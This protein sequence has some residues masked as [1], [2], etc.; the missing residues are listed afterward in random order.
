MRFS[1]MAFALS[2]CAL[3]A[4]PAAADEIPVSSRVSEVT[5]Y[6]GLAE[7]TR[8][9][10]LTLKQGRH[11]LILQNVPHS[12]RLS[13]LQVEIA[14]ARR[15][16]TQL[17]QD[18]APP[19]DAND[20][21]IEA[22]EARVRAAE[23]RIAAVRDEAERARAGVRAAEASIGFLQQLGG[24]EGLAQA[25]A[26]AL[27]AI[28]RMISEEAAGASQ[29]AVAAEAEARR[30]GLQLEDLEEDLAEARAAL[31]AIS[32]EDRDRLFIAVDIEA[33]Q[34]GDGAVT[35]RY[36]TE[37]AG[38]IGWQPSYEM[39]LS[40]MGEAA[41]EAELTLKRA[42]LLV[43]DTGEN[44]QDVAL[45]LSTAAPSG[46]G[47][48]SAL[49]PWLRRVEAPELPRPQKRLQSFDSELGALAAPAAEAAAV[50]E[51]ALEWSADRSG[52]AVTY[53]FGAPVTVASG[54]DLLRLE[55]DSLTAAAELRAVAVPLRDETAYRVVKF[56]NSFGEQLLGAA[57]VPRFADGKLIA[58][59]RFAGLAPGAEMEA[60]FGPVE[61]LQLRRDV[62]DQSEG[63]QGLISRS[64]QQVQAVEIEVENLTGQDW[65]VRVLDRVPYSQQ[66]DLEIGWSAKPRPAE[67]DVEKQRGILAWD[68][69]LAA[70]E[71]RT[72]RL[73][74]TLNWP[75]GM[76]LR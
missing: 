43:Q 12:A 38:N 73:D 31:A 58:V 48:P 46:Q 33:E 71:S 52:A 34:A 55:M 64:S 72:I 15:I 54:A 4:A 5:L 1:L 22:A 74:T 37:G 18:Y 8:S 24:N 13:T 56:T 41:G 44:W 14:G 10:A 3:A 57:E 70:G 20:P 27:S 25:D 21:E 35:V 7:V 17:R 19:R 40:T 66:D 61:G 49:H 76:V 6:P 50:A 75:E 28:A 30:I 2:C 60:G 11:R 9:A 26:A 29:A 45:T 16:A 36:L 59:E 51:E 69:E 63:G 23:A 32:L 47:S 53:R 42:V 39:H 67:E 62:L 68:L 65:A